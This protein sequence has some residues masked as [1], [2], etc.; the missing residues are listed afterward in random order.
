MNEELNR[1]EQ[2]KKFIG[3]SYQAVQSF[4]SILQPAKYSITD[5]INPGF[6]F[7]KI[8]LASEVQISEIT[9][10]PSNTTTEILLETPTNPEVDHIYLG[11]SLTLG[12]TRAVRLAVR[13]TDDTTDVFLEPEK[14]TNTIHVWNR[15][16][17]PFVV[18]SGAK[19]VITI[20]A[21]NAGDG[22][23]TLNFYRVARPAGLGPLVSQG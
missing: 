17:L 1:S 22:T 7:S 2:A 16:T 14:S 21:S 6:D 23:A 18:P 15:N 11:I 10:T 9:Q 4:L 12:T 19:L 13:N 20:I 3:R 5:K 8:V